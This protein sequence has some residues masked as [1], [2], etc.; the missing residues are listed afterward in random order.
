MERKGLYRDFF[1]H[2]DIL[3]MGVLFFLL[4]TAVSVF[5]FVW[6][7]VF[8]ILAGMVVFMFSEYFTHRFLFHLKPPKQRWLLNFLKRLHYDHHREPDNLKLLFLPVWYS[9]PNFLVL[10]AFFYWLTVDAA[11]TAAFGMG[12]I[13]MLL[14]YEWKHYVAHRPIKPLFKFGRWL[15][16]THQLHHYK[17]E[18][19]WYGVSNPIGD[20]LFGTLKNEKEVEKSQTAKDL[21]KRGLS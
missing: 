11:G 12:L 8:Y 15:K 6:M 2:G 4:G 16:K 7:N 21:E 20:L 14:V 5:G 9:I 13:F 1:L 3:I 10:A 19:Y 18:N 17:N